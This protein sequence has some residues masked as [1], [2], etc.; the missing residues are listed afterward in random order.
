V[1]PLLIHC[2]RIDDEDIATIARHDCAVAHCPASNAKLG[3]GIAPLSLLRAAAIRVG[4]G[5]DSVASNDRMDLLAE[6]RLAALLANA[7]EQRPDALSSA[8]ALALATIGGARALGLE[9][10]IGTLEPGKAA[11]ISAF[12][13][14]PHLLPLHDP[15]PSLVFALAGTRAHHVLVGG[16]V[17]V[18]DGRPV[19]DDGALAGRVQQSAEA[20]QR[21]LEG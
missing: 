2:V 12:R 18:R 13:V 8:D 19:S 6:T 15:V 1:R 17:L 16:R 5:S 20:L 14:P 11:D 21:W 7:R 10:E 9:H 3:H 4:L